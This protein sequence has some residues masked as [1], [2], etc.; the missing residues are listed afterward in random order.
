MRSELGKRLI[1][2]NMSKIFAGRAYIRL[3]LGK[4]HLVMNTSAPEMKDDQSQISK[5]VGE[6]Q[7][8]PL[9]SNPS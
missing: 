8:C 7:K 2:A 4:E 5:A 6:T 1:W 9:I 3:A